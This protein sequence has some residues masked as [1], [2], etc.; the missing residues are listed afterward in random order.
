MK[1]SSSIAASFS[2]SRLAAQL[3]AAAPRLKP[4]TPSPARCAPSC[5]TAHSSRSSRAST[6][7]CI[8][9]TSRAPASPSPKTCSP[10]A[11]NSRCAF[12]KSIPTPRKSR[13]ASSSSSPS[14]GRPRPSAIVAGQRVSGDVTRLTDFGAFVELEPGLEGLIH[15]SEMSWAKKV[16]HPSDLLKQGDRVDAVVL[17]VKP[18]R[19]EQA[20]SRSASSRP[21]PI[22]GSKCERKFPVG[23][24]VEGPVTKI[25]NFGAFVADRRR[26]RRPGARQRDRRRPPHQSSARRA[27]RGPARQGS[28]PRHRFGEAPDQAFDEAADPHQHRRVHRRAQGGRPRLRPRR[29]GHGFGRDRRTRRRHPRHLRVAAAAPSPQKLRRLRYDPMLRR[30]C[31]RARPLAALLDVEGSLE[32]QRACAVGRTRAARRRPDPNIQDREAEC[33]LER[34]SKWSWH[35]A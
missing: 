4:A 13:S 23:S 20:A 19:H 26:R 33:R 10:S 7:C 31:R 17:S 28:R 3:E 11:S 35:C 24:Q 15:I 22:P 14:R 29:R 1:M 34:R 30:T 18:P 21:S 2:K 5:P 25:M 6:A 9:A 12:S 8:S 32:R 16:R 27:A